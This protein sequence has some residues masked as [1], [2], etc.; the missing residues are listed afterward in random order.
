MKK[1]YRRYTRWICT[2]TVLWMGFAGMTAYALTPGP[3]SFV[4][5]ITSFDA[6][7]GNDSIT[8]TSFVDH[9]T[10]AASN[11]MFGGGGLSAVSGV[12]QTGFSVHF[13]S[14][15][16]WDVTD[17]V[18]VTG[19]GIIPPFL[20]FL[21]FANFS[22][23][24]QGHDYDIVVTGGLN[25]GFLSGTYSGNISIAPIPEPETYAMLLAGLLV[26][27]FAANRRRLSRQ[28]NLF[29]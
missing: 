29:A 3:L 20:N 22:G 19:T 15:E 13:T 27:G 7:Y 28:S 26:V 9:Y 16:L 1:V 10:F 25:S 17:N 24:T 6:N 14:I 12:T 21:G 8:S 23:L 18:W 5:N 2:A 11:A 4:N